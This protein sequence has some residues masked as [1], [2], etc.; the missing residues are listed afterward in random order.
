MTLLIRYGI[1]NGFLRYVQRPLCLAGLCVLLPLAAS[2]TE[3][4]AEAA[5]D[6]ASPAALVAARE[7]FREATE[8]VD[9]GRFEV[10]LEKFKRVAAVK[11]TAAVR[12]NIGRC[13]ESLGRTGT[14]LA[15][16]ELA[17]REAKSDPKAGDEIARL[18]HEHAG[19]VRPRVPRL[20]LLGTQ[21]SAAAPEGLV[22]SLDGGKL[23][24]GTLG[25][26]LPLDPGTHTVDATAPG[27]TPF[28]AEIALQAGDTKE[29]QIT[30]PGAASAPPDEDDAGAVS[31]RRTVGFVVAGGGVALGAGA[32]VFLVLH[33]GA[34]SDLD[35]LCPGGACGVG[36]DHT[37]ALDLQS[38]ARR[39]QALAIGFGAAS[40]VALGAGAYFLFSKPSSSHAS[41]AAWLA[42]SAPGAAAGLTVHATF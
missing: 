28:H 22:V 5:E 39:D 36:V 23:S 21:G 2:I 1:V 37:Q 20:T 41:P 19:A 34:V 15:D 12:F 35:A 9:A 25:V 31:R 18:A 14:A 10:A 29:V 17:E 3:R 40:V 32:L 33:N 24:A 38:R 42:P 7:L 27:R 26:P 13:E 6:E 4:R 30:V 11:E 16:F 8:D